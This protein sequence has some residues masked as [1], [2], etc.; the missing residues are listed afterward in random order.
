MVQC[1]PLE[2]ANKNYLEIVFYKFTFPD[3]TSHVD[4]S[5]CMHLAQPSHDPSLASALLY[6]DNCSLNCCSRSNGRKGGGGGK[7]RTLRKGFLG[8]GRIPSFPVSP[9]DAEIFTVTPT[10]LIPNPQLRTED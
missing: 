3:S 8:E 5:N 4:N 1:L 6:S 2:L 9:D 7:G 10:I